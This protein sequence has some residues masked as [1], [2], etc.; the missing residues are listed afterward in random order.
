[1]KIVYTATANAHISSQIRYLLDRGAPQAGK[2]LFHR[3]KSHVRDVIAAYPNA[4]RKVVEQDL[5]EAWIPRTRLVVLYRVD[6]ARGVLT[7]LAVFHASQNRSLFD[8]E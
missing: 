7:V 8:P 3:I 6:E 1:M 2:R 4:G 5:F